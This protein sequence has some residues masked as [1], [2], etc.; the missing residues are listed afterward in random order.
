MKETLTCALRSIHGPVVTGLLPAEALDAVTSVSAV[1]VPQG[2]VQAQ[3]VA[4]ALAQPPQL[5]RER[6]VEVVSVEQLRDGGQGTQLVLVGVPRPDADDV[7]SGH[8]G[9]DGFLYGASLKCS[10]TKN[11]DLAS[12][13]EHCCPSK[14]NTARLQE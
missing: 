2:G 8:P 9:S 7:D 11:L 5:V 14:Q 3:L 10:R 4:H 12:I 1:Q 6:R 13:C